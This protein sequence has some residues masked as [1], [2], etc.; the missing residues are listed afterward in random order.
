MIN[1]LEIKNQGILTS[2]RIRN[3]K[4]IETNKA[5]CQNLANKI[6]DNDNDDIWR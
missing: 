2:N 5:I 4:R 6:Y 3:G 1:I